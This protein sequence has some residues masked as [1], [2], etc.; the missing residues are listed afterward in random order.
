MKPFNGVLHNWWWNPD[1]GTISGDVYESPTWEDGKWI[2]TSSVIVLATRTIMWDL[3][4]T[5]YQITTRNSQYELGIPI[6]LALPKE[7]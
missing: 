2:T 6:V 5:A 7:G 4:S 1:D 3:D